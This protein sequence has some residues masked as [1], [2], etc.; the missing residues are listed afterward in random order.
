MGPIFLTSFYEYRIEVRPR[1]FCILKERKLCIYSYYSD[2]RL[3]E[4]ICKS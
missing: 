2:H 3:T 4:N 1:L